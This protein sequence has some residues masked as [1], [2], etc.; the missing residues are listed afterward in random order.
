[1]TTKIVPSDIEI[2]RQ[3]KMLPIE[4]VAARL[5]IPT[6]DLDH[7]GKYKAKVGLDFFQR[8]AQTKPGKLI[9]VTAISP[10]PAG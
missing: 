2:A 5:N 1:M 6:D 3:A 7:Y 9:L 4:K 10:T 8:H